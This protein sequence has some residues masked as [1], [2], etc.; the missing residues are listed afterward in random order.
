MR[1]EPDPERPIGRS[2]SRRQIYFVLAGLG[3][4]LP[5]WRF[6]PFV[7]NHGLDVPL[8]FHEAF[9]TPVG[10][11]FTMDVIISAATLWV[12]AIVEWRRGAIRRPW[13]PIAGSLLV[14]VSLGLPL[15]LY[16]RE[17]PP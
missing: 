1:P 10:G 14:G 7:G 12:F 15:L 11:F 9:A 2:R 6:L 3:V 13:I 4:V 17:P 16:L 5:Y 8:F